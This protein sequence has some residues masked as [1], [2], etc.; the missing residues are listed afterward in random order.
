MFKRED[1]RCRSQYDRCYVR[2]YTQS[3]ASQEEVSWTIDRTSDY[4]Y[5]VECTTQASLSEPI[6]QPRKTNPEITLSSSAN[7]G[8][9]LSFRHGVVA[10]ERAIKEVS[11]YR[12]YPIAVRQPLI[13]LC[14]CH[15]CPMCRKV[16]KQTVPHDSALKLFE[17]RQTSGPP[18]THR[19]ETGQEKHGRGTKGVVGVRRGIKA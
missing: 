3:A 14:T 17:T 12:T 16:A 10:F 11:V 9:P 6:L 1:I 8:S 4:P 7:M 18:S 15:P 2:P 13:R 5:R 19:R